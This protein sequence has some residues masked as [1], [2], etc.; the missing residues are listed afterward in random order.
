MSRRGKGGD[1][2]SG[3]KYGANAV[4]YTPFC[5]W[6][7]EMFRTTRPDAKTDTPACRRA[8]QRY[9]KKHGQPPMFPFGH[10]RKEKKKVET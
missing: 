5:L 9:V 2:R 1:R 4:K 6:C 8:L 10:V 7:G 3:K